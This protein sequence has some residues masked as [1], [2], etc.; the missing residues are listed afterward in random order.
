VVHNSSCVKLLFRT[1]MEAS[2]LLW[3]T[4]AWTGEFGDNYLQNTEIEGGFISPS[5]LQL[6]LRLEDIFVSKDT[7]LKIFGYED[8]ETFDEAKS[9]SSKLHRCYFYAAE[10]EKIQRNETDVDLEE[11][12]KSILSDLTD[13]SIGEYLVIPSGWLAV[14]SGHFV[15]FVIQR[16]VDSDQGETEV[17]RR[18]FTFTIVNT[19]DGLQ[20]HSREFV[21]EDGTVKERARSFVL[22]RVCGYRLLDPSLIFF[23][24]KQN[25]SSESFHGP[26]SIYDIVVMHLSGE[27]LDDHDAPDGGD[28]P[29]PL[30]SIQKSG[31]CY[32]RGLN[33]SVKFICEHI[34]GW[35]LQK[36]KR[37]MLALRCS[38]LVAAEG[39]LAEE[40][41]RLQIERQESVQ[42][43]GLKS[44]PLLDSDVNLIN[45]GLQQTARAVG[46]AVLRNH[47]D[48][49]CL[50]LVEK[51]SDALHERVG[52][53][54]E[55]SNRLGSSTLPCTLNWT[56]AD[57]H[58][59]TSKD[60]S[61]L[62]WPHFDLIST[63]GSVNTEPFA[64]VS[65]STN[66]DLF[67]DFI[68]LVPSN[69]RWTFES[70]ES[71]LKR[72]V[73]QISE[74]RT[75]ISQLGLGFGANRFYSIISCIEEL[76]LKIIPTPCGYVQARAVG[77][78]WNCVEK[79][80]I[81]P[82]T[83]TQLSIMKLTGEIIRN[84]LVCFI[85]KMR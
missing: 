43:S 73:K 74:E 69:P 55:L 35:D 41:A 75:K 84:Y 47:V 13:L 11:L 71:A 81:L 46:K 70:V 44:S 56:P 58:L 53:C 10:I 34:F 76:V 27:R 67:A 2:S 82:Q 37:L 64:G 14:A 3:R 23:L 63:I 72:A 22:R 17:D 59:K 5:V 57:A 24:L 9:L 66:P 32:F 15:A 62:K 51:V 29:A 77:T 38:Y 30:K 48:K 7:L 40:C 25:L 39:Q 4:A 20:F 6:H 36:T 85:N 78:G 12:I 65:V 49:S 8:P 16:E 60:R 19:G 80:E 50:L 31:T 1:T 42:F 52:K 61:V 79:R 33:A 26:R 28:T 83:Y 68:P 18:R 54:L 21:T 45:L